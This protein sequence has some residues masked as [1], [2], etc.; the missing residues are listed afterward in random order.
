MSESDLDK[1]SSSR[2]A[3]VE[4]AS[5]RRRIVVVNT[6]FLMLV[7]AFTIQGVSSIDIRIYNLPQMCLTNFVPKSFINLDSSTAKSFYRAESVCFWFRQSCE[8]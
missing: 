3:L 4:R 6:A 8:Q 2:R 5:N 1:Q 7:Y